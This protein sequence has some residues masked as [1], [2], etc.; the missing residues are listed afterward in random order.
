MEFKVNE[1][2]IPALITCNKEELKQWAISKT[3]SYKNLLYLNDQMDAAKKQVAEFRRIVK[4][5]NDEKIRQKKEYMKPMDAFYADVKEITDIF[6]ESIDAI[7]KQIKETDDVRRQ[8]KRTAIEELFASMGFQNFVTLDMIFDDRW[9][10]KSETMKKIEEAMRSEMYRIS[11][12]VLTLSKLPEFSFEATEVYKTTLD[13]NK[14]IAEGHRLSEIAKQKAEH[15]AQIAREKEVLAAKKA[16][17]EARKQ[18]EQ[19]QTGGT[20]SNE[21]FAQAINPPVE[22]AP[23]KQWISF[24]ACMTTEDAIALKEFFNSRNIEFKRV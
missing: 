9:L 20:I 16:E 4:A 5:M 1:Y 11:N 18:A 7:D 14:A 15:D 21:Q 19:P 22:E 6:Q 2:Q 13:V 23:K 12:D 10:N 24:S 8:E 3:E 17:L